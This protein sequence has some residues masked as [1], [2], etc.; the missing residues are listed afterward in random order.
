MATWAEFEAAEPDLAAF[1]RECLDRFGP[2]GLLLGFLATVRADGGP[3]V[4]PVC[5]FLCDGRVYVGI[6]ESSPKRRDLRVNPKYMLHSFPYEQDPEFSFRGQA[7][8]INDDAE[9]ASAVA[10]V[11][12]ASGLQGEDDVFELDIERADAT[13]WENWAQP[14]TYPVRRTWRQ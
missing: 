1:G 3:R 9:R 4:H 14:D 12:Y 6:P 10:A 8:L 5:P 11:P 2:P 13:T 7:R